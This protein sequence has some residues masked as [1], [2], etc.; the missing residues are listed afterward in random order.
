MPA[1]DWRRTAKRVLTLEWIDGMRDRRSR[2]AAR[3]GPRPSGAA[4]LTVLRSFLRH[5]MRDGFFHADMHQGNLLVDGEGASS[6][7]TS[8]SWAGSAPRSAASWPKSCTASSRAT[9]AAPP[10]STS[11]PATCRRTIPSRCSR[12]RCARSASRSRAAP[13]ARSPWP[14]CWASCSP[15]PRCST[16]RRG[17]SCSLLG[18][19]ERADGGADDVP[20]CAHPT[21]WRGAEHHRLEHR[22]LA[23]SRNCAAATS[24]SST[25]STPA[26]HWAV[27]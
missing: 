10:R 12:R 3:R 4:D 24:Q 2:R 11:R 26:S 19:E 22:R 18:G 23:E 15:T 9:T 25:A 16:W 1:V 13:P 8:A 14:T 6:R 5:A 17:P 7:S 21:A 27:R 20:R